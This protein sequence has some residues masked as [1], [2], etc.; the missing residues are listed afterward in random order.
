MKYQNDNL[1][2][3]WWK[4][5]KAIAKTYFLNEKPF[6]CKASQFFNPY[7]YFKYWHLWIGEGHFRKGIAAAN[8]RA[9]KAT[10]GIYGSCN[11]MKY[12]LHKIS[13]IYR[14]TLPNGLL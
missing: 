5:Q 3:T 6:K 11:S 9:R 4:D 7:C 2:Q 13:R 12:D 10:E 1:L 8:L 14:E